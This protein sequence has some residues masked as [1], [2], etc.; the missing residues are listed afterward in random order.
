MSEAR[1]RPITG[2]HLYTLPRC[3]HAVSLDLHGDRAL[4][5]ALREDEEFLLARGRDHE[6]EY[7]ASLDWPE[8]DYLRGDFVAG[9]AATR[10][11]LESG[12][13]GVLQ[14]VLVAPTESGE[15]ESGRSGRALETVGIPDLLRRV[16]GASALGDFHYQVGDVKSSSRP[17]GDQVLQLSLYAHLLALV[18]DRFATEGFLV[19][20]DGREES[21]DLSDFR[22]AFEDALD[23]VRELRAQPALS[24]P[25]FA[26]ACDHC[27]WSVVCTP[28]LVERD[29]LSLVDGM[30][31]GM[32]T[33]IETA[34]VATASKLARVQVARLARDTRIESAMVRRLVR[35]AKARL[36]GEPV[37]EKRRGSVD[38]DDIAFV[39]VL[40]DGFLDRA[41][42]FGA[43]HVGQTGVV[44]SVVCPPS[45]ELEWAAFE[46]LVSGVPPA[47]RLAHHGRAL[48]TWFARHGAHRDGAMA[49]EDRFVDVERRLRSAAHW[50]EPVHDFASLVRVG[51]GR[52]PHREGRVEAA[53]MWGDEA[54][55]AAKMR[56]DLDDLKA[57]VERWL[58]GAAELEVA[59]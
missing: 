57:L 51:L 37:A 26:A 44:C 56:Q 40:Q 22:P 45:Q 3:A 10:A 33:M 20:K 16:D 32:R 48:R 30:T 12:V 47:S 4:R 39:H 19:M 24:R 23:R 8:P 35:A 34:G 29:D 59:E 18:Q 43:L 31:V 42:C 2:T 14:A 13:P 52:D 5:R 36:G 11:L 49:I 17:R 55:L 9:A 54:A 50:P 15:A 27:S 21:I 58:R 7:V 6:A 38:G 28:E 1:I 41:L 25:F 53:S 46:K